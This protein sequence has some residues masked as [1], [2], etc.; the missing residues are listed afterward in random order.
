MVFNMFTELC[1]NHHHLT[2][3]HFHHCE[4]L[5]HTYEVTPHASCLQALAAT[6]LWS[7]SVDLPVLYIAHTWN[8][9]I[10][11]FL[12]N[13]WLLSRSMFSWLIHSIACIRTFYG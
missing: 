1:I 7:V 12:Y 5:S 9:A 8:H 3:E 6:S 13:I 10:C 4:K 2:S 11:G